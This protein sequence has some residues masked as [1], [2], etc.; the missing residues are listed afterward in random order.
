MKPHLLDE[1]RLKCIFEPLEVA[2]PNGDAFARLGGVIFTNAMGFHAVVLH[3]ET[4]LRRSKQ[5][6]W[7]W[8]VVHYVP[9]R[10]DGFLEPSVGTSYVVY[11]IF[12]FSNVATQ[13]THSSFK[14]YFTGMTT[15]DVVY[16]AKDITETTT[17]WK[18][19]GRPTIKL[20]ALSTLFEA[21][22]KENMVVVNVNGG[23]RA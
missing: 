11:I 7:N 17:Q 16:L 19:I 12:N 8:H 23:V 14:D 20:A 1:V 4:R 5:K 6:V 2:E 10:K 13:P 21:H 18:R 22:L 3:L 15:L 9:S